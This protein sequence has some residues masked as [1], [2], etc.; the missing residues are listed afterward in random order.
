MKKKESF[1][2]EARFGNFTDIDGTII[3][4][5]RVNGLLKP[6]NIVLDVGCGK[7]TIDKENIPFRKYLRTIRGKV[8]K[9]IG[10]DIDKDAGVNPY[11]D[12]F[13][14]IKNESWPI[15]D[16]SIDLI[17]S[18]SVLEHIDNPEVFFLEAHRVLKNDGYICLR[19]PNRWGYVALF[20][21][22]IPN[23]YHA[24][25]L[26]FTQ[27][28]REEE[29]VFPTLY[30]CNSIGKIK[31]M[32]KKHDFEYVVYGYECEPSYLGFST[33]AYRIG[34]LHQKI[35]PGFL[36]DTIIAFGKRLSS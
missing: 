28:E 34:V 21:S 25:I 6:S 1:Y 17:I 14:L 32:M 7:S 31:K 4:Y 35:A 22:L 18:D 5:T 19:T 10:I 12:E 15:D 11:I 8:T 2:P 27:G 20:A 36:R 24:K 33:I 30:K 26:K 9:V 23:K 13:R 16:E 29:D 3:F